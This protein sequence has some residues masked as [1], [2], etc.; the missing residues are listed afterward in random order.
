MTDSAVSRNTDG[1]SGQ[2]KD[3]LAYGVTRL[4]QDWMEKTVD[5]A[6]ADKVF[7]ARLGPTA[8]VPE[9]R[10]IESL[11]FPNL[12]VKSDND[13]LDDYSEWSQTQGSSQT[14]NWQDSDAKSPFGSEYNFTIEE[15]LNNPTNFF[16]ADM[17]GEWPY[18][19][20]EDDPA[21]GGAYGLQDTVGGLG[22]NQ[23]LDARPQKFAMN[24]GILDDTTSFDHPIAGNSTTNPGLWPSIPETSLLLEP[25]LGRTMR[26]SNVPQNRSRAQPTNH[27]C[28]RCTGAFGRAGDLR[29]HYRV[30]FPD[31]RTFHCRLEGCSRNG[32]R[33]FYRRDKFRDHQRQVHGIGGETELVLLEHV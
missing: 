6:D 12:T 19:D 20:F 2:D 7:T 11:S 8:Y 33:G 27:L 32:Q 17:V 3:Q 28:D 1:N 21:R 9:I 16:E 14:I 29:R 18:S 10:V 31:Y 22:G 15:L 23:K 24:D 5:G 25:S 13:S 4:P 26:R 30:H